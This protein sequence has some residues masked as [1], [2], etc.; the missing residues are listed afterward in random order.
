VA[1]RGRGDAWFLLNASPDLRQQIMA[2]PQ[3]G[4]AAGDRRGTGIAGVILTDAEID[5]T[6]GLVLVREGCS[7]DVYSTPTVH[8]WLHDAYPVGRI[9]T[10]F[11][12]RSWHEIQPGT[13]FEP[14]LPDG[15]QSGLEITPFL[16]DPHVP[17]FVSEK[18]ADADDSVIGLL[19]ADRDSGKRLVYAPCVAS[20]TD[21]FRS[22]AA[23]ADAVLVD[24]TFWNDEE[25][26]DIGIGHRTAT[27]MGHLPVSGAGGTLA[28]LSELDV[29]ERM[30]VHFFNTNPMLNHSSA[31]YAEVTSHGVLVGADGDM[32]TL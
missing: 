27:Q 25:P 8:R 15:I 24:G 17:R 22:L 10:Y 14:R 9:I 3:L 11:G 28:W 26:L 7:L 20:L 2:F 31:E 29:A 18:H 12:D 19:I 5:H 1:V 13:P 30:Y 21:E 4:P 23:T 16:L 32:L 6:T